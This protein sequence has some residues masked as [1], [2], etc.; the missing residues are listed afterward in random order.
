MTVLTPRESEKRAD[1]FDCELARLIGHADVI[2][3]SWTEIALDLAAVRTRV[4]KLMSATDRE[5]S[6]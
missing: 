1:W 5:R 4:R 2:N 6:S 3:P